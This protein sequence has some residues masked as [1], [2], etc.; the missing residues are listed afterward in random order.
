VT[1][2]NVAGSGKTVFGVKL[3]DDYC[4]SSR[5][6][7]KDTPWLAGLGFLD[8]NRSVTGEAGAR[9]SHIMA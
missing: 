2:F 4:V 7:R 5:P 6:P 3:N 1:G 8:W 9:E